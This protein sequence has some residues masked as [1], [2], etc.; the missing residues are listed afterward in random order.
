TAPARTN[1]TRSLANGQRSPD[2]ISTTD[3]E[4][5]ARRST[6]SADG[7]VRGRKASGSAAIR[8]AFLV[9]EE[10][11]RGRRHASPSLSFAKPPWGRRGRGRARAARALRPRAA[12][13]GAARG[14]GA[15]SDRGL[16]AIGV[17]RRA[18]APGRRPCV[19]PDA[20]KGADP[21]YGPRGVTGPSWH[22]RVAALD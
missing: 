1:A 18:E 4:G 17:P 13:A 10:C 19:P 16:R 11:T 7:R 5:S 8:I 21:G 20:P 3:D 14:G 15:P 2:A 9:G 12:A 22:P 6:P